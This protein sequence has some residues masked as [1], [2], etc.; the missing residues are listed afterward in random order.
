MI[1]RLVAFPTV[2][3]ESNLRLI[4]FVQS[5]LA[6]HGI[7]SR[8]TFNDDGSKANLFTTIG[9]PCAGGI[10]LSRHPDVVPVSGQRWSS[11]P[12]CV[13]R[14]GERLYGRGTA[15]MKSFLAIA[16]GMV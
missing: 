10:V 2:S 4:E 13:Q 11:D 16:L 15:D 9:P 6:G 14:R 3:S 5:E 8:L 1:E 7:D 12:F